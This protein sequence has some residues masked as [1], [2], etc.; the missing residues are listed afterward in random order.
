M[1]YSWETDGPWGF[2]LFIHI[3]WVYPILRHQPQG[4]QGGPS[5]PA[6]LAEHL[7]CGPWFSWILYLYLYLN[8]YI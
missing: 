4:R 2:N 3:L 8:I 6:R 1:E 7:S 5:R